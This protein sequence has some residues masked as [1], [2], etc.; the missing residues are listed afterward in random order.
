MSLRSFVQA[1]YHEFTQ[2]HPD[3]WDWFKFAAFT[4]GP[5]WAVTSVLAAFIKGLPLVDWGAA[6]IVISA[7][8]DLLRYGLV[9]LFRVN[10]RP[11]S[12]SESSRAGTGP[13]A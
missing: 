2:D 10:R 8:G 11:T 9:R 13:G 6:W 5:S 3:A 1:R 7:G 12:S 4:G